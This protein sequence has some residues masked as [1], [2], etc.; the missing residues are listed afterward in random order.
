[1]NLQHRT[2]VFGIFFGYTRTF[3]YCL[4]HAVS[5][6]CQA[7]ITSANQRAEVAAHSTQTASHGKSIEI[8]CIR[9]TPK[10]LA[11]P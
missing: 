9:T 5:Y 7:S 1:M 10:E 3:L 6:C 11:Q 2:M 4:I 8:I